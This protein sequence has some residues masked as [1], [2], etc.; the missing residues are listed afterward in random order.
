[1]ALLPSRDSREQDLGELLHWRRFEMSVWQGFG[2][3]QCRSRSK[4]PA[5]G[6][7]SMASLP[8]WGDAWKP[9]NGTGQLAQPR[10]GSAWLIVAHS[11]AHTGCAMCLLEWRK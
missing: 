9:R 11:R 1:L 10:W 2:R 3:S 6:S 7:L 4:S 5:Q 8:R